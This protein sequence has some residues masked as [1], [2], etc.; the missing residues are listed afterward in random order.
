MPWSGDGFPDVLVVDHD[1]EF[2]SE[3]F[4]AF[5]TSMGST[6]IVGLAYHK[7]TNAKLER[8]NGVIGDRDTLHAYAKGRKDDWDDHLALAVLAI[9][10]VTSTLGGDLTPF[11]I[12]R[13][14]HPRLPLSLP[15]DDRT[16]FAPLSRRRST[17]P[18]RTRAIE[19]AVRE[20]L[21]AAQAE[22]KAKLDAA[23][24]TRCSRWAT[25][26]CCGPKSCSTPPTLVSC[27]RGG[28]ALSRSRPA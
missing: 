28:T 5:V 20:L 18:Q 10:N 8:A 13:G 27:A 1:A 25:A 19:T 9:N 4:R 11:F 14:A 16:G 15:R 23:G 22:R 3:V 24:S 7:N 6:L 21:A 2:T 12:D 17:T 26:C